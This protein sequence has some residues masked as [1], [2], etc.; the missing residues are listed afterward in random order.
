MCHGDL[1]ALE[2]QDWPLHML[3]KLIDGVNVGVDQFKSQDLGPGWYPSWSSGQLSGT[4]ITRVS[5]PAR[6]AGLL[7]LQLDR[8]WPV[9]SLSCPWDKLISAF[10]T[11]ASSTVLPR[12]GARTAPQNPAASEG[13]G[14]LCTALGYS[15]GPS[16]QPRAGM[17][18]WTFMVTWAMDIDTDLC[19]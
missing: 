10:E 5:S 14:Q 17:S 15:P 7:K 13:Q 11:R 6:P 8:A 2:L 4:H 1:A 3:Q 16:Q 19:C 18:A 9:L 12:G